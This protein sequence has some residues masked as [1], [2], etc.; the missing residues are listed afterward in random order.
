MGTANLH[1]DVP[2]EEYFDAV[3]AAITDGHP[4]ND[5]LASIYRELPTSRRKL[6]E[7]P[8]QSVSIA[9][10][11]C[12]DVL[13]PHHVLMIQQAW[14]MTTKDPGIFKPSVL[15][16]L[17][18]DE[19]VRRLKD[20]RP[21]LTWPERAVMLAALPWVVAVVG[22]GD[23]DDDKDTP[24]RI[25]EILKVPMIAQIWGKPGQS[26]TI[27]HNPRGIPVLMLPSLVM[28][29]GCFASSS[30]LFPDTK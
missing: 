14:R 3:N 23:D 2:Y 30:R 12:F 16:A 19:S 29:N 4:R 15:I 11:G 17:N 25:F 13:M 10:S 18:S 22:F 21:R 24:S 7:G 6:A 5:S 26:A 27:V 20:K 8:F 9:M 1:V 28:P